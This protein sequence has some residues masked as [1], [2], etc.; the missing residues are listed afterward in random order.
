M[1]VLIHV[2]KLQALFWIELQFVFQ[3]LYSKLGKPIEQ[4]L[5]GW[6]FVV[7]ASPTHKN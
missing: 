6:N 7:L 1:S 3:W 2:P 4:Q 5:N